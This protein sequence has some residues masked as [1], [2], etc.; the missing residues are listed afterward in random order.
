MIA[1]VDEAE[2]TDP[3][4]TSGAQL[5]TLQ[6]TRATLTVSEPVSR[7]YWMDHLAALQSLPFAVHGYGAYFTWG[8]LDARYRANMTL[9]EAIV[10]LGSVLHELQTRFIMQMPKLSVKVIDAEGIKDVE[11]DWPK[12]ISNASLKQATDSLSSSQSC[13]K[14][15]RNTKEAMEVQFL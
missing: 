13:W 7:L 11:V 3:K 14:F 9:A 8:L 2:T 15:T 10:L 1:G 4:A 6:S 12:L 5:S